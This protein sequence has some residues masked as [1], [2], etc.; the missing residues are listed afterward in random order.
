MVAQNRGSVV[1]VWVP[2]AKRISEA[3]AVDMVSARKRGDVTDPSTLR[4]RRG[5]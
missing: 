3:V 2:T 4:V 5:L 1:L